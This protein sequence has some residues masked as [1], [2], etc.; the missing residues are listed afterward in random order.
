[1]K[2]YAYIYFPCISL[3]TGI[4]PLVSAVLH[5]HVPMEVSMVTVM[6]HLV[7][8]SVRREWKEVIVL[9]VLKATLTSRTT[10]VQ[11]RN[12]PHCVSFNWYKVTYLK[13]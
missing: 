13:Y 1:M 12:R 4:L 2:S 9:L 6:S 5:V 11:V 10:A 7:Y 3:V 8:A